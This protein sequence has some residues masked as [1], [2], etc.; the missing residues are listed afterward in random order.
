MIARRFKGRARAS[1]V[2]AAVVASLAAW[3]APAPSGAVGE[4]QILAVAIDETDRL[5]VSWKLEL[6]TTFDFL[7][8]SSIP[9]SNP[10]IPGAFA[11]R[12]IVASTCVQPGDGCLAPPSLAAFRSTDRVARDRRYYVKVNARQAGRGP[13]SSPIWVVD[14]RKPMLPGGGRP[15]D[16]P[17]GKPVFGQ[18][19]TAPPRDAIPAPRLRLPRAPTKIATV[20]RRGVRAQLR[21]PKFVCYAIVGLQLGKRT[22]VFSDTTARASAVATFVL[23][24]RPNVQGLLQRRRRARLQVFADFRS[25]GDKQTRLIRRFTVRR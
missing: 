10:F 2:G 3:I 8:F 6:G 11:N 22:L 1:W 9:M 20:L 7:E 13:L 25:P 19:Y 23:R 21:C 12:N 15:S 4:P 17:T 24:P 5:A 18:P 16:T 14:E